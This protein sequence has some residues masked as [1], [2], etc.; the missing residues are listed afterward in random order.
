MDKLT[1]EEKKSIAKD[2]FDDVTIN[3]GLELTN[4]D[5]LKVMD[6]NNAIGIHSGLEFGSDIECLV[7]I[8]KNFSQR[9]SQYDFH[10]IEKVDDTTYC[11]V[12]HKI[13]DEEW[14]TSDAIN[15]DDFAYLADLDELIKKYNGRFKVNDARQIWKD[16]LRMGWVED[17][18]I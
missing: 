2:A 6:A 15:H 4:P 10:S 17:K 3:G 8:N 18:T 16:L 12:Y 13:Y 9:W 5:N 7:T 11:P 14:T 1:N